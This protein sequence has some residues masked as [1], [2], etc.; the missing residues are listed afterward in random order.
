MTDVIVEGGTTQDNAILLLAAVE[1]LGED[2]SVV[3]TT[4]KG[5]VA[6]AVVVKK[7][8]LKGYD[9][10]ADFNDEVDEAVKAADAADKAR[11]KAAANKADADAPKPAKKAAAKKAP[12][13]KAAAKKAAAPAPIEAPAQATPADAASKE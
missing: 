3:Q 7:A 13:K 4:S 12:A 1:E 6:P 10:D 8:G 2:P 5:F 9:P 11:E